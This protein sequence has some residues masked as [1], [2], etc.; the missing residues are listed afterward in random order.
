MKELGCPRNDMYEVALWEDILTI[1]GQEGDYA[2]Q[3][4]NQAI[5]IPENMDAIRALAGRERS[6]QNSNERTNHSLFANASFES[7]TSAVEGR[8]VRLQRLM[9]SS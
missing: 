8:G 5:V 1:D 4:D 7:L 6:A 9:S 2:Y 3:V